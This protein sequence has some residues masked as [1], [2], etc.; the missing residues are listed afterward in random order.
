MK[1]RSRIVLIISLVLEILFIFFTAFCLILGAEAPI[2][3]I[4]LLFGDLT[5]SLPG[6]IR[7]LKKLNESETQNNHLEDKNRKEDS[8]MS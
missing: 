3:C 2:V 5:I 4:L 7:Q 1:N 6:T 8:S